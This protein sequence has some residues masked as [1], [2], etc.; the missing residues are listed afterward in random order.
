MDEQMRFTI[1]FDLEDTKT[2]HQYW[3]QIFET[4]KWSEG[5]YTQTFE[6]K[7]TKLH[8]AHSVAFC[9]WSGAA[10][11]ALKYFEL[12]GKT[13]LCPSNTFMATPLATLNAG[14]KV[15]F[16]DCNQN[17]FCVS[18]DDLKKK[19]E[20][21]KPAAVWV[22]HIGGHIAFEIQ[23]IADYCKSKGIILLEDCAHAHGA[24]WNGQKAGTW[25]GSSGARPRRPR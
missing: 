11:A 18:L 19:V 4:Q 15:E 24:S 16:V 6:D 10:M 9:S 21:Y 20:L 7:W 22:V 17:D 1:G 23:E 3:G 8:Q 12:A 5:L 25:A 2:V 13:V 14:A